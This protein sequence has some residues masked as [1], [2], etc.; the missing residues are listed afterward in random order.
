MSKK[1]NFDLTVDSNALLCPN[2]KE[3]FAKALLG[4]D[5][6]ADFRQLPN[7]KESTKLGSL[8]FG[9]V[10]QEYGC[11][12]NGTDGVLDAITITP[13][14]LAIMTQICQGDLEDSFVADWMRQGSNDANFGPNNFMSWYYDRVAAAANNDIALIA[15]QG[16]TSG[17]IAPF[18]KCDGLEKKLTADATVID[19]IGTTVT[20]ANALAEIA[21]VVNALPDTI[22]H[23]RKDLR[24]YVS[25]NVASAYMIAASSLMV[26][27]YVS[28][29]APLQYQGI[30]IIIASGM[31]DNTMVASLANNFIY[32]YDLLGDLEAINTIQM[33]ATTGD[34]LLRTR[35]NFKFFV[36]FTNGDA[37]VYYS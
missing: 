26:N 14:K 9:T 3:W 25:S 29:A 22:A 28:E 16:D 31:S 24:I 5:E 8:E 13:C 18:D 10:V 33:L 32:G 20:A 7:I 30:K 19:V 2:P 27:Q 12:F 6:L 34:D 4:V 11:A 17:T 21:K 1:L 23:R 37:I 15:W 35:T 36:G